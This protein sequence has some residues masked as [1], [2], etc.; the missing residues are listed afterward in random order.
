MVSAQRHARSDRSRSSAATR[1][2]VLRLMLDSFLAGSEI[3]VS[4]FL[5]M[6][7]INGFCWLDGDIYSASTQA[8]GESAPLPI[9]VGSLGYR[10]LRQC[11]NLRPP[12]S[13]KLNGNT[14]NNLRRANLHI[15]AN[16][17]SPVLLGVFSWIPPKSPR[18]KELRK[19]VRTPRA[20]PQATRRKPTKEHFLPL[21]GTNSRFD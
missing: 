20:E 5:L 11:A 18:L 14:C 7:R 2:W 8:F 10:D 9:A 4:S 17:C 12:R 21:K 6:E 16:R 1:G 3:N 13:C 19:I 15:A